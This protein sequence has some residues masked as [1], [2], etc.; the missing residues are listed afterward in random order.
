MAQLGVT[1]MNEQRER[2]LKQLQSTRDYLFDLYDKT[3]RSEIKLALRLVGREIKRLK[4]ARTQERRALNQGKPWAKREDDYLRNACSRPTESKAEAK[5]V[6]K[7]SAE[8]LLRTDAETYSRMRALGLTDNLRA[9]AQQETPTAA[10]IEVEPVAAFSATRGNWSSVRR[11]K[12][13]EVNISRINP[14]LKK[15]T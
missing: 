1:R 12:T 6:L 3:D 14:L 4:I 13:G 8:H 7:D 2:L 9:W 15:A 5:R 11:R 10:V